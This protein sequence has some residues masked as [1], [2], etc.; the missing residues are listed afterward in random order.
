MLGDCTHTSTEISLQ[1]IFLPLYLP[2]ALSCLPNLLLLGLPHRPPAAVLH[3][4]DKRSPEPSCTCS[5]L[6]LNSAHQ[7]RR[8]LP[9]GGARP[10]S[11]PHVQ[12]ESIDQQAAGAGSPA[13]HRHV[14][15]HAPEALL[16]VWPGENAFSSAAAAGSENS[17]EQQ[18]MSAK[19]RGNRA[20]TR[21]VS[22][23]GLQQEGLS[24]AERKSAGHVCQ[25]QNT[26]VKHEPK[27]QRSGSMK[28]NI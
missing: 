9:A 16:S 25:D 7:S 4:A 8:C 3:R 17:L 14:R 1:N 15:G 2:L 6:L 13:C 20:R 24:L 12:P 23:L 5:F 22:L 21:A 19:R 11:A 28:T 26:P 18:E 27:A 10:L